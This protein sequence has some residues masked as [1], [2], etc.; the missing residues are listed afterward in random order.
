MTTIK[1]QAQAKRRLK[2]IERTSY[3]FTHAIGVMEVDGWFGR[4]EGTKGLSNCEVRRTDQYGE[5][6]TDDI[7]FNGGAVCAGI[8]IDGAASLYAKM[9]RWNNDRKLKLVTDHLNLFQTLNG[10][11]PRDGAMFQGIA[12]WNDHEV[13]N[14][15]D[16]KAAFAHALKTLTAEKW[17]LIDK[18]NLTNSPTPIS[19]G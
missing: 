11:T 5:S 16:V 12:T 19:H 3:I 10:R 4:G 7:C 6:W 1:T 9:R 2:E 8:A 13:T 17:Q 14:Y 18:F 15:E